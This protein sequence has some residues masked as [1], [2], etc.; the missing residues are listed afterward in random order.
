MKFGRTTS[1]YPYACTRV[2]A[3][4]R[5]LIQKDEYLRL[6][7]MDLPSINRYIGDSQYKTEIEALSSEYRG[8][9]LVER[10]TNANLALT[11]NQI[12]SFCEGQ[13]GELVSHYLRWNERTKGAA[14]LR[15]I[16]GVLVLLGGVYLIYVA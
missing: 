2:R 7:V 11:Y 13:L 8:A 12:M 10:A 3:K 16:C 15:R 5:F 1:N 4:R 6:S 9:D 14:A